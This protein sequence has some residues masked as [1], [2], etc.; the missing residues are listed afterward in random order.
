MSIEL[1]LEDSKKWYKH[2]S[3]LNLLESCELL[4]ETFS[5]TLP[6]EFVKGIDFVDLFIDS[7]N[8]LNSERQFEKMIELYDAIVSQKQVC[9][10]EFYYVDKNMMDYYLFMGDLDGVKKHLESFKAFPIKSI[11]TFYNI[12]AKLTFYNY[13]EIALDVALSIYPKISGSD[14]LVPGADGAYARF[15]YLEKVQEIYQLLKNGGTIE[16]AKIIKYLKKF[17]FAV[18]G[19]LVTIEGMLSDDLIGHPDFIDF[20]ETNAAFLFNTMLYFSK[21]MF[22]EKNVSFPAASSIWFGAMGILIS[23]DPEEYGDF[24][25][26]FT[27]DPEKFRNEI[28]NSF[29]F[30]SSN[31]ASAFAIAWGM[32]YVYDFLKKY[33][34]ISDEVHDTAMIEISS[35]KAEITKA[36]ADELWTYNFVHH[37]GKP[38]SV[39][40]QDFIIEKEAF[41]HTFRNKLE[42]VKE[43]K[44]TFKKVDKRAS[45]NRCPCGSGKKYKNC[46]ENKISS[47]TSNVA[48]QGT[49][50]M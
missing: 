37:W 21:Y 3:T 43:P 35:I 11:D 20:Y 10:E 41:E 26:V 13:T 17:G 15:I 8:S 33:D 42:I 44:R 38:D 49:F 22:E 29:G 47:D 23:E 4:K 50:D 34:Y 1:L 2:Y 40:E 30:L 45:N 48:E 31:T 36:R 24:D 6:E 18:K 46:C 12:F 7:F 14:K 16:K 39:N 9:G 5:N 28:F 32:T 27:I 19:Q 25:E